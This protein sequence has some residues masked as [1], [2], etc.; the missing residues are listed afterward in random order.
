MHLLRHLPASTPRPRTLLAQPALSFNADVA[1]T[2][3]LPQSDAVTF[4]PAPRQP[5]TLFSGDLAT[6][7]PLEMSDAEAMTGTSGPR[8]AV[9][10]PGLGTL[11]RVLNEPPRIVQAIQAA[12]SELR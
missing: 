11:N 12:V 7:G 3:S 2:S 10:R 9:G 6:T 1:N 8:R 4:A 5:A